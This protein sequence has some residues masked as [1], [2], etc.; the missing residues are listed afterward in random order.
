MII[1][2]LMFLT[3]RQVKLKIVVAPKY[4]Y[5]RHGSTVEEAASGADLETQRIKIFIDFFTSSWNGDTI[6]QGHFSL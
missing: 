6:H 3:P 5:T 4:P 2:M 1:Y